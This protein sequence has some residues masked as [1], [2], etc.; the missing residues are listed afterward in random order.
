MLLFSKG[1][2]G[3]V[4]SCVFCDSKIFKQC[5]KLV[6]YSF[7][8]VENLASVNL[9]AAAIVAY[10]FFIIGFSLENVS[11]VTAPGEN[12]ISGFID[13]I[14]KGHISMITLNVS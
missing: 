6:L 8:V 11:I 13:R 1:Y 14:T 7:T 5:R 2:F 10:S 12:T 9:I 3:Q 4:W